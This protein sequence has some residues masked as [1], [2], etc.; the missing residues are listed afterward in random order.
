M[1]DISPGDKAIVITGASSGI[2][3]AT[4]L[5][6]DRQGFRVFATVRTEDAAAQLRKDASPRLEVIFL[7]LAELAR[8][9][10]VGAQ[11]RE[12]LQAEGLWGLVNNAGVALTGPVEFLDP[13]IWH[14]QFAVNFFGHI[15][16]T[17]QLLPLLRARRGR[18]I[19]I[20]SISGRI[21]PPYFGPYTCSKFALEGLSDVL[22]VELRRFGIQVIVVEPGNT[23]T[24]I[25]E[26][27]RKFSDDQF[28]TWEDKLQSLP[29][30]VRALYEADF[31]AMRKATEV[32]GRTGRNVETVVRTIIHA[33]TARR[34][35]AR[36]PVG[37]QV[38]ATF[39][40]F[41]FLPERLRDRII[42][43]ALRLP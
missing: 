10:A 14:Y 33:L 26:R 1:T 21:A 25:W 38:K 12:K 40:L 42:C 32:M 31:E 39:L 27:A 35:K 36:Y 8:I 7:D 30:D 24:P 16:L 9:Q 6:L 15:E 23:A 17:R 4:A 37:W 13:E 2:G 5:E 22:R 34:P 43:W 20:T 3:R 19:N 28:R 41:R 29:A 18:I 11:L